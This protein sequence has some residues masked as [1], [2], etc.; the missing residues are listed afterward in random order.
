MKSFRLRCLCLRYRPRLIRR[1]TPEILNRISNQLTRVMARIRRHRHTGADLSMM[2]MTGILH[3]HPMVPSPDP[4]VHL[5][6]F[7]LNLRF[8][9]PRRDTVVRPRL[10]PDMKK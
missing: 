2:T 10:P 9:P 5:R 3:Q 6:Q 7:P 4:V 8:I 1:L